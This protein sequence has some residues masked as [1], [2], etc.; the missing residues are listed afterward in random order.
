MEFSAFM[1]LRAFVLNVGSFLSV[2][3]TYTHTYLLCECISWWGYKTTHRVSR[4]FY[5]VFPI[6]PLMRFN[7]PNV[8]FSYGHSVYKSCNF[9]Y[10]LYVQPWCNLWTQ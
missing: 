8:Y 7:V 1:Y 3:H 9:W 2:I 5:S 10:L 4:L 6:S